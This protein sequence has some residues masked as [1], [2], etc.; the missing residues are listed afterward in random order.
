MVVAYLYC[1]LENISS[2]LP[3]CE[4]YDKVEE[5]K[6]RKCELKV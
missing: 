4:K 1:K 2:P 6:E 3:F 5:K